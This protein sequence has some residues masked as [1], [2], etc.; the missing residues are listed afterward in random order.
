MHFNTPQEAETA[1]YAAFAEADIEAMMAV[2]AND[3]TISCVHP[4]GQ[5][6]DGH[7]AVRQSWQ[8][9]FKHSPKMQFVLNETRQWQGLDLAIHLVHEHIRIGQ[10]QEFQAPM[11]TTNVYRRSNNSWH[12]ISHHASPS[13]QAKLTMLSPVL[14]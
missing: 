6:L 8:N 11:V 12:M 4:L 5:R 13:P 3:D 10:N 1:F 7:A 14:H 9:L 2:W